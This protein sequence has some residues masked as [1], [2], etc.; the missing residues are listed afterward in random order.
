MKFIKLIT[1]YAPFLTEYIFNVI[2]I[3]DKDNSK[4][5]SIKCC[6]Y[7]EVNNL[8]IDNNSLK[9]I[10]LFKKVLIQTRATRSKSK[11]IESIR[12]P[13]QLITIYHNDRE[14]LNF[15]EEFI[16]IFK[17]ELNSLYVKTEEI[18]KY[19]KFKIIPNM[20]SIAKDYKMYMKNIKNILLEISQENMNSFYNNITTNIIYE[21]MILTKEHISIIPIVEY[22]CPN[23]TVY[24]IDD[25][26]IIAI[27]TEQ[28]E[29]VINEY[30]VRQIIIYIQKERK[31]L[32]IHS[33]DKINIEINVNIKQYINIITNYKEKINKKIHNIFNI[34]N[35]I[36]CDKKII[37]FNDNIICLLGI[38]IT[39]I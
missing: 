32:N 18:N 1:P 21:N 29:E 20:K 26:M 36:L 33:Y 17:N 10:D 39:F 19:I 6:N 31:E 30:I 34:N 35:D 24:S 12:K 3:I 13:I 15:I 7:P 27:N 11:N 9:K 37:D 4:Y 16:D 23:N 5:L 25:S 38:K 22:I 8:L 2:K 28:T 14:F